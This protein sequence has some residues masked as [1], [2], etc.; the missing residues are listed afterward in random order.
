LFL[1]ASL[2]H[3]WRDLLPDV[4]LSLFILGLLAL[5]HR[6]IDEPLRHLRGIAGWMIFGFLAWAVSWLVLRHVDDLSIPGTGWPLA[7]GLGLV[8]EQ[9]LCLTYVGAV[10]LLLARWPHWT[11]R[12]A[13][14]GWTGRVALTNY[15]LQAAVLD[16]LTSGYGLHTKLRPL[17]YV[18]AALLLF[19]V[20][21]AFSRAWLARY[22]YG[23]LE[24]LWRIVTYARWQPIRLSG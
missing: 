18:G 6:Y 16:F 1:G 24:W 3:G 7:Y 12:L 23:P 14:F 21:A 19:A 8:Q 13:V 20:Q 2:P 10:V 4:N 15:F 11:A 5:R 17:R 9:W 22:R